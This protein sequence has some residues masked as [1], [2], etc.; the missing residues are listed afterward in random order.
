[1]Q[2]QGIELEV[3]P[4]AAKLHKES[5]D[6]FTNYTAVPSALKEIRILGL[7]A[8]FCRLKMKYVFQYLPKCHSQYLAHKI[9]VLTPFLSIQILLDSYSRALHVGSIYTLF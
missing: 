9:F 2:D 1:M 5:L 3:T 8:Y 7:K 4:S 6:S